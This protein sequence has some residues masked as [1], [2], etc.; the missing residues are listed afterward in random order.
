[1][2][3]KQMNSLNELIEEILNTEEVIEFK[4]LEKLILDKEELKLKL[5]R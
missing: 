5:D 2:V 3:K 1:M 4:K